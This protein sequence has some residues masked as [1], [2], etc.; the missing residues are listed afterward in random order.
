MRKVELLCN[1]EWIEI[2]FSK[3]RE[4]D[5]YRVFEVT[6]EQVLDEDGHGIFIAESDAV[7]VDGPAMY[8]V[9]DRPWGKISGK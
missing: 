3:I 8:C 7:K 1:D 2:P 9:K 6:G 5:I 4:G